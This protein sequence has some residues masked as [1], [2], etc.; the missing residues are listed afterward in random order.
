MF[1]NKRKKNIFNNIKRFY[2]ISVYWYSFSQSFLVSTVFNF[3]SKSLEFFVIIYSTIEFFLSFKKDIVFNNLGYLRHTN[4]VK[5]PFKRT[6]F[7]LARL[8]IFLPKIF[9]TVLVN[10]ENLSILDFGKSFFQ[11]IL[12]FEIFLLKIKQIFF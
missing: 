3:C 1:K 10:F 9:N 5:V 7:G 4:H 8:S 12:F 11:T 2:N 6:K